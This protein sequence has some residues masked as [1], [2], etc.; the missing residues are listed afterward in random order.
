MKPLSTARRIW[1]LRNM[2]VG[3]ARLIPDPHR[4]SKIIALLNEEITE[5]GGKPQ[6]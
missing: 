4:R 1:L 6:Q 3:L 2:I 5:A